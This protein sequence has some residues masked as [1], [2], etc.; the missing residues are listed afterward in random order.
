MNNSINESTGSLS[1]T[2]SFKIINYK[3]GEY[4]IEIKLNQKNEFVGVQAVSVDKIFYDYHSVRG[5]FDVS[6]YYEDPA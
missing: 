2:D 1:I 3:L 5:E 4:N 6:K